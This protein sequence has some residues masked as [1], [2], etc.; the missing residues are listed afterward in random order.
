[1]EAAL[2][3]ERAKHHEPADTTGI[4]TPEEAGYV[5]EVHIVRGED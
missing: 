5:S 3:A 4:P 1:L 2:A